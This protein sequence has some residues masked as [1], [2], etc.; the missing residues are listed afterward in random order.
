MSLEEIS[1]FSQTIAAVAIVVSLIYAV[2]Q[3]RIYARAAF[4]TRHLAA[5]SDLQAFRRM[6]ATDPDC[7]RIYRDGLADPTK[8]DSTDTWRFG[9]LMELVVANFAYAHRYEKVWRAET[10][11]QFRRV[12]RRPGFQTW[13]RMG[14]TSFPSEIGALVDRIVQS[15]ASAMT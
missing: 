9:A 13:W 1:Y 4:D 15:T 10:D 2:L 5:Q 14:R 8:L 6:I 3:V 7:A 11:L 12:M